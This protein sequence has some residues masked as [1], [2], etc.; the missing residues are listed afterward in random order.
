MNII[1]DQMEGQL[2]G[3]DNIFAE[4]RAKQE[5]A[6]IRFKKTTLRRRMMKKKFDQ[7]LKEQSKTLKEALESLLDEKL[8]ETDPE[9]AA[10]FERLRDTFNAFDG[11]GSGELQFPEYVEA[12]KFLNQPGG[13]QQMK[14]AFDSVDVDNS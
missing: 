8:V 11:D 1:M 14:Q 6:R 2:E 12:W 9:E 4:H 5:E 10:F 3:I 7:Q 13:E